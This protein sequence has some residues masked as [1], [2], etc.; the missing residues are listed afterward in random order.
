MREL[1]KQYVAQH[2]LMADPWYYHVHRL[3]MLFIA[4]LFASGVWLGGRIELNRPLGLIT[5]AVLLGISAVVMHVRSQRGWTIAC[6]LPA[7]LLLGVYFGFKSGP[8]AEDS[9][10]S[11]ATTDWQ[12]CAMRVVIQSAAV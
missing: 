4:I 12:P 10:S 6:A 8:P 11:I 7:V 2:W 1:Y 9:L 5:L 3:P